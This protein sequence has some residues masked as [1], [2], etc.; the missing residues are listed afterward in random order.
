MLT[1]VAEAVGTEQGGFEASSNGELLTLLEELLMR[2]AVLIFL[3][4][5][6]RGDDAAGLA[7]GRAL[8][9]RV[10]PRRVVLCGE[11]LESCTS[12]I[13]RRKPKLAVLVDAVDA[14]LPPG[15]VVVASV[16]SEGSPPPLSTH[17]LPK[18]LLLKL[19]GVE[20]AW[21]LGVQ[22]GSRS[23][24]APLTPEV[25]AA[26]SSLAKLLLGLLGKKR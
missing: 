23:V 1:R 24:G 3:G 10:D 22:V 19:L 25:A 9:G 4:N 17:G 14:G 12:R 16:R 11:G 15:S 13:R 26:C 5:E 6:L 20:E 21:I 18:A 7:V 2:G 8:A